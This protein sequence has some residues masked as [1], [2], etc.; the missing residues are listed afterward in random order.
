M[1]RRL[2]LE[3]SFLGWVGLDTSQRDYGARWCAP[4]RRKDGFGVKGA[5][6]EWLAPFQDQL[7]L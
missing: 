3:P 7:S 4:A 5:R 6:Q 1:G 2:P